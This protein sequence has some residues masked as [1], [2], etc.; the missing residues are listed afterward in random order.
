MDDYNYYNYC[1]LNQIQYAGYP[2][3]K[4]KLQLCSLPLGFQLLAMLQYTCSY[5]LLHFDLLQV[6]TVFQ[7]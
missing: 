3:L 5:L 2:A 6:S 4:D 7:N 1:V